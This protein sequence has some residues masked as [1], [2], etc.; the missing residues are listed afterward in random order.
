MPTELF[1]VQ[2]QEQITSAIQSAENETSG[3]IRVHLEKSCMG[4]V[5][6]RAAQ[7]FENLAMHKTKLRNGVLFY[8][9]YE[10]R[11]FAILGDA[12]INS[13]VPENF[14]DDIKI[15]M[16]SRFRAG[17][18]VEGLCEGVEMAGNQLKSNF[19][20]END[21]INELPDKISFG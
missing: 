12:G 14:W 13:T 21:D 17:H 11:K 1:S 16:Q 7:V 9:A 2:D 18:F 20:R 4:N 8:L 19:P 3:E 10:D 6:D 15:R 5:L